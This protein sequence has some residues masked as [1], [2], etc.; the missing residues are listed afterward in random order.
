MKNVL[1]HL[2]IQG[3]KDGVNRKLNLLFLFEFT[4]FKW[5]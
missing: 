2:I 1:N 4:S 5:L 3:Y